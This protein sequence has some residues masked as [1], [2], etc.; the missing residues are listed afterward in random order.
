MEIQKTKKI[1]FWR[2]IAALVDQTRKE[3]LKHFKDKMAIIKK[4]KVISNGGR[5]K[6]RLV[7]TKN[8][9]LI[10]QIKHTFSAFTKA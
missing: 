3:I 7:S 9:E 8:E 1:V 4:K 2:I 5:K 6:D 10:Q